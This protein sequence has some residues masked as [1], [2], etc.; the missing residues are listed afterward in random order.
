MKEF[1]EICLISVVGLSVAFVV[2]GLIANTK[3]Y[4]RYD[5]WVCKKTMPKDFP[6]EEL[7]NDTD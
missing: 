2:V 6:C 4:K 5:L 1:I 7:K 3:L